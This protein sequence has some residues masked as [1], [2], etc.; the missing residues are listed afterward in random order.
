VTGNTNGW[1]ASGAG[2]VKS[3]GNNSIDGNVGGQT[4]P[5]GIPP[6]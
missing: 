4:A 5:P 3:Y 1:L 6:K 2:V